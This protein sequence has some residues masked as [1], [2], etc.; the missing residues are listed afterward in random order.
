MIT[1]IYDAVFCCNVVIL[2]KPMF[3]FWNHKYFSK[4]YLTDMTKPN[5][6]NVICCNRIKWIRHYLKCKLIE[7]IFWKQ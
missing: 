3:M 6:L 2:I 4:S 5:K 7:E 1:F